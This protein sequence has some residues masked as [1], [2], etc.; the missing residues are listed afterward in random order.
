MER[1]VVTRAMIGICHMQ[2]CA[3][4]DVTDEEILDVCN[5]ENPSG[6]SNG[7]ASVIR[8]Q[9]DNPE[10]WGG[11]KMLPVKCDD[12]PERLHFLVAC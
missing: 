6:T 7:W 11:D 4:K 2:V 12:D 3:I 1:V 8:E 5:A 10:F 9:G